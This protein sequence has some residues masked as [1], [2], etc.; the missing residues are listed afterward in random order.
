M[1]IVL[2]NRNEITEIIEC[3]T[4]EIV[5]IDE[6]PTISFVNGDQEGGQLIRVNATIFVLDLCEY[7]IGE[8][9]DLESLSQR[10]R[11]EEFIKEVS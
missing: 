3:T 6:K 11:K 10:D 5:Y 2:V 4:L 9:V 8:S 1:F 7:E